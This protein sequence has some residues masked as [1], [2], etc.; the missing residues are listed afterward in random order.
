MLVIDSISE[1]DM[2]HFCFEVAPPAPPAYYLCPPCILGLGLGGGRGLGDG[3]LM[4]IT[5]P[6]VTT[7]IFA[8]FMFSP[9]LVGDCKFYGRKVLPLLSQPIYEFEYMKP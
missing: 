9:S 7:V 3:G 6:G 5:G 2:G 8:L 4:M 1:K